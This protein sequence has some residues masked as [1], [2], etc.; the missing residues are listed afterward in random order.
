MRNY[1]TGE[2]R[3]ASG[4]MFVALYKFITRHVT[5]LVWFET[6]RRNLLLDAFSHFRFRCWFF[7]YLRRWR[8][9]PLNRAQLLTQL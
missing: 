8:A 6:P 7:G 4:Q 3:S 5:Y 1:S 9:Y 2:V